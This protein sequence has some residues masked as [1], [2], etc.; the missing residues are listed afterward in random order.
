MTITLQ[1]QIL[2]YEKRV[3]NMTDTI[4]LMQS[5][6]ERCKQCIKSTQDLTDATTE[7]VSYQK[8][9]RSQLLIML[10]VAHWISKQRNLTFT[11]KK[12]LIQ[13]FRMGRLHLT[14]TTVIE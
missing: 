10:S 1:D 6:I 4:S 2:V 11:K 9:L 7:Y 14:Q 3:E 5:E 8:R 12:E 13:L